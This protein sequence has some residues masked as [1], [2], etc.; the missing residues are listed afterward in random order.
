MQEWACLFTEGLDAEMLYL[1]DNVEEV[2]AAHGKEL[3][4]KLMQS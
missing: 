1:E 2:L 3:A 4:D